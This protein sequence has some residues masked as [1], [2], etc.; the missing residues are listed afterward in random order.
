MARLEFQTKTEANHRCMSVFVKAIVPDELPVQTPC[1][2]QQT[3]GCFAI[4][5]FGSWK[6]RVGCLSI[7]VFWKTLKT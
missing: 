3:C 4:P 1:T 6:M 5:D 2:N 7:F